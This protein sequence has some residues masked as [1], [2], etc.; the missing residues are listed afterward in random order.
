MK[1]FFINEEEQAELRDL[2]G[3]EEASR[4]S[5]ALNIPQAEKTPGRNGHQNGE[6]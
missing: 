5:K 1:G 3:N 2:A 4:T 6:N